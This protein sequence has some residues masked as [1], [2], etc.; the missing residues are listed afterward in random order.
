[1]NHLLGGVTLDWS[2][3]GGAVLVA[4]LA[5]TVVGVVVDKRRRDLV[6]LYRGLYE[7]KQAEN[8]E[9]SARMTRVEHRLELFESSY[10][11]KLAEGVTDAVVRLVTKRST[12]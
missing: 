10:M 5:S 9:L 6:E 3:V 8:V 12:E 7:G 1:M 11:A 2:T 4:G